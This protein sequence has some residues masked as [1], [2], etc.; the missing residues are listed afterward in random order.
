MPLREELAFPVEASRR[1]IERVE[2]AF[3]LKLTPVEDAMKRM[4][5]D[6]VL[7]F[8]QGMVRFSLYKDQL[9]C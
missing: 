6:P 3:Q 9:H 2:L 8:A 4:L 1:R 7:K 5:A